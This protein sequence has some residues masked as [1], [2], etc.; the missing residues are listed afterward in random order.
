M[1]IW[2]SAG[3]MAIVMV[4]SA[5]GVLF[6]IRRRERLSGERVMR[7]CFRSGEPEVWGR[8]L[9]LQEAR[10][11]QVFTAHVRAAHGDKELNWAPFIIGDRK[12]SKFLAAQWQK[13][14]AV[15]TLAETGRE[16]IERLAA[17]LE[18][19]AAAI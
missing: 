10:Y 9:R 11:R 19:Y 12:Q 15:P 18:M 5:A 3:L 1:D 4:V 2:D 6:Y 16:R 13:V 8:Q 7:S 14:A 17:M